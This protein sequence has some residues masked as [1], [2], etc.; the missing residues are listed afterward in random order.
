[1]ADSVNFKKQIMYLTEFG[2]S[3][4][5]LYN[6]QHISVF[7]VLAIPGA[8]IGFLLV[9]RNIES[10]RRQELKAIQQQQRSKQH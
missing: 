4:I 2:L 9:K 6:N 3:P 1:M 8:V 7:R 5:I 10:Q